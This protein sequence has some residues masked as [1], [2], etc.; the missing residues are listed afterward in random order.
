MKQSRS[1]QGCTG[2]SDC[3]RDD[4][5]P[6]D[7]CN[8]LKVVWTGCRIPNAVKLLQIEGGG[9]NHDIQGAGAI[10]GLPAPVPQARSGAL[11][12][13]RLTI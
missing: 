11:I 4:R 1:L 9:H 8:I 13:M 12:L 7:G 6:N 10:R 2:Q 3:F 5:D